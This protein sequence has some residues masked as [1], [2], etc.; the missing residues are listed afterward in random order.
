MAASIRIQSEGPMNTFEG[1]ITINYNVT[2]TSPLG[3]VQ[4]LSLA[5]GDNV[6]SVPTGATAVI[7][8]PPTGN[9]YVWQIGG[10]TNPGPGMSPSQ[11]TFLALTTGLTTFHIWNAGAGAI[12][13]LFTW[14]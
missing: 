7:M 14:F 5:V 8:Q 2:I 3:I 4:S 11:G 13:M 6:I 10:P 9:A 12:I 1:Q